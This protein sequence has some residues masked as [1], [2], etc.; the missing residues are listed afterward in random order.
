MWRQHHINKLQGTAFFLQMATGAALVLSQILILTITSNL[1]RIT[2][3]TCSSLILLWHRLHPLIDKR[4]QKF[5]WQLKHTL[6]VVASLITRGAG[7]HKQNAFGLWVWQWCENIT[8]TWWNIHK[9]NM[10]NFRQRNKYHNVTIKPFKR[11]Q[12]LELWT[13]LLLNI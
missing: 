6:R 5:S 9:Q 3:Q 10:N 2:R 11:H 4:L 7:S 8:T 12:G 1:G 13:V